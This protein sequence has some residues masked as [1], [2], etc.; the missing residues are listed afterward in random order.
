[1]D[2]TEKLDEICVLAEL[3]DCQQAHVAIE[4]GEKHNRNPDKLE[5]VRAR[6]KDDYIQ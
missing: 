6:N 3:P 5:L 2:G 4:M 1:M